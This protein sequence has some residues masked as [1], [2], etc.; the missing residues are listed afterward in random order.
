MELALNRLDFMR[1][2]AMCCCSRPK[3]HVAGSSLARSSRVSLNFD[4]VAQDSAVQSA[5]IAKPMNKRKK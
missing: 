5:A 2:S 4:A 3:S 1:A